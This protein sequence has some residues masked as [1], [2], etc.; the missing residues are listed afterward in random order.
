M[1]ITQANDLNNLLYMLHAT[2]VTDNIGLGQIAVE[3]GK[4]QTLSK[5]KEKLAKGN[6]WI[7]K[8]D[9]KE[10]A[11]FKEILPELTV[12]ANGLILKERESGYQLLC[13]KRQS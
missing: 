12:T 13:R 5:I 2:P 3:T 11:Q 4:D 8:S 1:F 9:T 7:H 6:R 10:V